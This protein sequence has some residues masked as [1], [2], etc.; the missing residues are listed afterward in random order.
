[1]GRE[2]RLVTLVADPFPPYQYVRDGAL[3]GLDYEIIQQ[4]FRSQGLDISVALHPWDECV[5]Q[6]DE[7]RADGA[8]QVAK[9]PER[10]RRFLFSDL[11]RTARTVFY[12]HASTPVG[13][14]R[15]GLAAQLRELTTAVVSGYSYGAT[16]DDLAD[17][18]K[19]AADSN[20]A[21]LLALAAR[22]ADLAIV[23]DGVGA[24][25]LAALRLGDTL[26][27]V[28]DFEMQRPL[29]V[30]FNP[31]REDFR[32]AFDRGQTEIRRRGVYAA[33]MAKYGLT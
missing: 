7:Q 13:L 20:E 32:A 22:R 16:F 17:I 14:R 1:M 25:L 29:F 26:R 4:A 12:C 27:R 19:L 2:D 23:D 10:E 33:L 3:A 28:P 11:L 31:G 18:P 8:F 6:M 30:A 5:R 24:H 21:G 9:T 15:D